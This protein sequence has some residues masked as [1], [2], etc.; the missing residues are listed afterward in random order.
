MSVAKEVFGKFNQ[1][2]RRWMKK[3]WL[4]INKA[5]DF[6]RTIVNYS[7]QMYS[8]N[9]IPLLSG[10]CMSTQLLIYHGCSVI[11]NCWKIWQRILAVYKEVNLNIKIVNPSRIQKCSEI[12]ESKKS[13][14]IISDD[15]EILLKLLLWRWLS[16]RAKPNL[17]RTPSVDW[18]LR[19]AYRYKM[20]RRIFRDRMQK[21][22]WCSTKYVEAFTPF[23][24]SETT[25]IGISL[26]VDIQVVLKKYFSDY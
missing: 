24:A 10:D 14:K 11:T 17:K 12:Q 25:K 1:V 9:Q 13:R 26:S 4:G 20:S 15:M 16:F 22:D 2:Q 3:C 6:R 21:Y 18:S 23:K 5:R 19:L 7:C 8:L